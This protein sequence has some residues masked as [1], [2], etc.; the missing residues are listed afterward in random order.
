MKISKI[1]I[2]LFGTALL[3]S[4]GAIA[5]DTNKATLIVT[6]KLNVEGK[7]IDP[8]TYKVEWDGNGPRVHV[9]LLK[10]KQT[11]ASFSAHLTEQAAKNAGDAYGSVEQADGSKSLAA[12]YPGG[13]RA[14][15]EVDQAAAANRQSS[16]QDSK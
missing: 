1:A 15:L 5:K 4:S 3:F 10:G 9:T 12:I 14:V 16:T 13:K 8:G 11:V 2:A 7:A 6:D